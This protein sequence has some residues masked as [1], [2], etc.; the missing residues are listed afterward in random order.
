M[1]V[2]DMKS[3]LFALAIAGI[4]PQHCLPIMLDV[5]TNNEV[6]SEK[7]VK[8]IGFL[9]P[10]RRK[11]LPIPCISVYAK[12][13]SQE[14]NMMSFLM[15]SWKLLCNGT[16]RCHNVPT[17]HRESF[18]ADLDGTVWFNSKILPVKMPT[19]CWNAINRNIAPSTMIFK[20]RIC[21]KQASSAKDHR[22]DL[23]G[24]ASVVIAGL[25]GALRITQ[26]KLSENTYL[27]VGAGQVS[28]KVSTHQQ[29]M[30]IISSF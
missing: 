8:K 15:N 4:P 10:L 22:L 3:N 28:E 18:S 21:F 19:D 7:N 25:F 17:H 20:V 29:K 24:T 13:E 12:S 23:S 6:R 26:K 30:K 16:E 14:S 1:N 27:F 11:F 9:L 5:G 2:I